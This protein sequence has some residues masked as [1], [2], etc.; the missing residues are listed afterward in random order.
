[1]NKGLKEKIALLN[2]EEKYQEIVDIVLA[3]KEEERV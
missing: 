3:T 2:D 1:M